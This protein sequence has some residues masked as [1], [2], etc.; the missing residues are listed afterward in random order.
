MNKVRVVSKPD[1]IRHDLVETH[2]KQA[3]PAAQGLH[4]LRVKKR[5]AAG[6]AEDAYSLGMSILKE[7]H[8]RGDV[9]PV[10]PFDGDAAMGAGKV[11]LV[12]AGE[13]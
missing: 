12:R 3:R 8:G 6:E 11:A 4:K 9:Q 7:A 2:A 1:A 5:L 10:S 13:G